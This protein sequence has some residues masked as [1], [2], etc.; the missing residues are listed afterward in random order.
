MRGVEPTGQIRMYRSD[1]EKLRH[2]ARVRSIQQGRR[3][4]TPEAVRA[5]IAENK[6]LRQRCYYLEI[7]Q[8]VAPKCQQFGGA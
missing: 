1:I 4:D 5:L 6:R 3:I 8:A 2:C 7:T